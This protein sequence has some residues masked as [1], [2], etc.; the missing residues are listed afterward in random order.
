MRISEKL[1]DR[2]IGTVEHKEIRK[3]RN[4]NRQI[5]DRM[6]FPYRVEI[7]TATSAHDR[8]PDKAMAQTGRQHQHVQ[9]M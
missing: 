1:P 5:R 2:T 6:V 3:F 7:Y 4:S 9:F 8:R